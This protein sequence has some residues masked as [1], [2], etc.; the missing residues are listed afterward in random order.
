M[1]QHKKQ[2]TTLP[3]LQLSHAFPT[4][5]PA[6]ADAQLRHPALAR[7]VYVAHHNARDGE[8]GEAIIRL[9]AP[10]SSLHSLEDKWSKD[11]GK[12]ENKGSGVLDYAKKNV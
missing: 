3:P 2:C 5:L 4:M 1:S 6:H 9:S 7:G 8:R 12:S 11:I 10:S